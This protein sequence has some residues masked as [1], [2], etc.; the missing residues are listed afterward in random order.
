MFCICSQTGNESM[1]AQPVEVEQQCGSSD[2]VNGF[3]SMRVMGI[4]SP[5]LRGH[6]GS[7]VASCLG[8]LT[9]RAGNIDDVVT[10]GRRILGV[11]GNPMPIRESTPVA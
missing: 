3:K 6:R 11:P 4:F 1:R 5:W 9:K 2:S 8:G 7:A 10:R